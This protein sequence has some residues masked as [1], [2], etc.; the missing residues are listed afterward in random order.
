MS[1]NSDLN[2]KDIVTDYND[3]EVPAEETS[4]YG[5]FL[6]EKN[7]TQL[8]FEKPESDDENVLTENSD[9]SDEDIITVNNDCLSE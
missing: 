1:E 5:N 6:L 2:D 4:F 3:S 7:V 9:L 8:P